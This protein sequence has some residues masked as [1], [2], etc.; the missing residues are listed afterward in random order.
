MYNMSDI[1]YVMVL[2]LCICVRIT[3]R[4]DEDRLCFYPSIDNNICSKIQ[5]SM[6]G[7]Y[8]KERTGNV[9]LIVYPKRM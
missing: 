2:M 1:F 3:R 7:C 8:K 4:N 5:V 9:I 6:C